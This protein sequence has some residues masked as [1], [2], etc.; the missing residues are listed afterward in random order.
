MLGFLILFSIFS[1]IHLSFIKTS[2]EDTIKKY[3]LV[4]SGLIFIFSLFLWINFDLLSPAY[5]FTLSLNWI[6]MYNYI[7]V[8]GVDGLSLFFILLSTLLIFLCILGSWDTVKHS[9]KEYFLCF[10]ALDILLILVFSVG[11]IFLFYIFFESILIPMFLIIGIWGSRERKIRAVYLFFFYTLIGSLFMLLA[12][13]YIYNI[14]GTTNY[15][16]ILRINFSIEEQKWLWL[17]FFLSLASKIPLFPFHVWL[18]EAHVEAPTSGSVLLAGILLKLGTYGFLRFSLPLFPDASLYFSPLVFTLSILGIIFT[19]LTA[20][21]QTDFKRIIAYSSVAHMNLVLMGIFSFH[22]PGLEGSL[23]Q[24]LSHGFV[25]SALFFLIGVLYDRYHSRLV[26]YYGGLVH[27]MPLYTLIFLL[28]TMAN[29][30]LPGTSSFIGEFLIL[31]GIYKYNTIA[32]IL[33][34]TGMILGGGYSLWLF[35]RIAY[36]NIKIDY[37]LRFSDINLREFSILLPLVLGTLVMGIY[38]NLFLDYIHTWFFYVLT[39]FII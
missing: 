25:S 4:Y 2:K 34:T 38:P 19:S 27:T 20:M 6:P 32:A 14:A 23:L 33:G 15:E 39:P 12:I 29:I 22:L 26:L 7:I 24:S 21:R 13:L 1:F 18:P 37:T 11:D 10:L 36:G 17:A 30:A 9:V 8:F 28:F 35:N 3:S 5:Q 31:A 16:A